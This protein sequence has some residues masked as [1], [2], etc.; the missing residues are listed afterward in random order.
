LGDRLYAVGST[1]KFHCLDKKT[2][3]PHWS[4]NLHEEF[5]MAGYGG[6]APSPIRYEDN[7][8][9]P[10]GGAGQA[11]VA[12][13]RTTGAVAWKS[14]NFK[15]AP[16]SPMLINLEGE[17]Q[18][19][20]FGPQEVVGLN[21][22]NGSLLWSHP[23]PTQY[24]LNI[25]TP[26]WGDGN[27]L[28]SSSAYNGGSRTIRLRRNQGRTTAE[29]LWFNNRMRVHFGNALRIGDLILGSSGDFGPAFFAALNIRS[30]AEVWR[31]RSF[32]RSHL[33]YVDGKILIVDENGVLA[34]ATATPR[35]L[36]VHARTVKLAAN[37]WT[38]PTL[39][40]HRLYL[41]DRKDVLALDL[42]LR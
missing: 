40:G 34:L 39:V 15:L 22:R 21:P 13:H 5:K 10:V 38:P 16:A 17:D 6:Y 11:V 9:L 32:G 33:L 20:V 42:G 3:K 27:L 12:F 41:R 4:H 1:G 23:H 26:V 25:S 18:L 37:A 31:E 2:G 7:V 28:F 29:E 24:G 19:V 14:Q 30:G 8:I 35:G 36:E